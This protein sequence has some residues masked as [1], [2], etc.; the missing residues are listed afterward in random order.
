MNLEFDLVSL[1]SYDQV[2][3][4]GSSV[5]SIGSGVLGFSDFAF[6]TTNWYGDTGIYYLFATNTAISGSL[7]GGNLTGSLGAYYL[8]T[9][10]FSND[11]TDVILTVTM[12]P[13]PE[14]A[15]Y[16]ALA[17]LALSGLSLTSIIRRRKTVRK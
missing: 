7:D 5:L 14:P 13:I 9:I 1:S 10:G 6:N 17:G 16:G 8:G 2:L 3:L 4:A 12:V 11:G 15:T